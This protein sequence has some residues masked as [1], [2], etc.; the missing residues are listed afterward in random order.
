MHSNCILKILLCFTQWISDIKKTMLILRQKALEQRNKECIPYTKIQIYTNLFK[1][2]TL[3]RQYAMRICYSLVVS[4]D[5]LV[6][7]STACLKNNLSSIEAEI[8][9][10]P[11]NKILHR[12]AGNNIIIV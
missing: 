1:A 4:V 5:C 6:S 8:H 3:D 2:C 12:I 9:T 7:S 10:A 11:A